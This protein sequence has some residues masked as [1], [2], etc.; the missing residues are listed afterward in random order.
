MVQSQ[1]GADLVEAATNSY[2]GCW[3]MGFEIGE[4][5]DTGNGVMYRNSAIRP[6]DITDGLS[7]TMAVGERGALFART[8]WI[9]AIN[10]GTVQITPNAPVNGT[11]VEEAPVEVMASINGWTPLNDAD[12]NPYLFF[13]P[14]GNVVQFA[15][16]D[17]AVHPLRTS[18]SLPVLG[19][20]ATRAGSE[21]VSG[22]DF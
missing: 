14:H 21:V 19:A 2:A 7:T 18:T 13:S 11:I 4:R 20:M 12:S 3:G 22:D 6:V 8:P 17:G 9:G 10:M 16:A 5:P 15:F 1:S